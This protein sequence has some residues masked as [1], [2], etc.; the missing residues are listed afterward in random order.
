MI[1]TFVDTFLRCFASV[2]Y[3]SDDLIKMMVKHPGHDLNNLAILHKRELLDRLKELVTIEKTEGVMMKAY[4]IPPHV[5][6]A[7]TLTTLCEKVVELMSTA[8]KRAEELSETVSAAIEKKAW[9]S[10]HVS[11]EKLK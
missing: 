7:R 4:G 11:G 10:G 1:L 8:D 3:H 5:I 2:V 6:H 9:E